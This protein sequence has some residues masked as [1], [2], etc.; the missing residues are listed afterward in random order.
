MEL[1]LARL[2]EQHPEFRMLRVE[3]SESKAENLNAAL[4]V[5]TGEI[6][7]IFFKTRET[8][9]GSRF[10]DNQPKDIRRV[11]SKIGKIRVDTSRP[12]NSSDPPSLCW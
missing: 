10:P 4:D 2:Q 9:F 11:M 7:G 3:G 5:V 8:A 6:C 1:E 12:E